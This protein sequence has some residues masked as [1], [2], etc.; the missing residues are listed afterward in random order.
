MKISQ[1]ACID[2]LVDHFDIISTSLV[3]A[4][5]S[6]GFRARQKGEEVCTKWYRGSL[7]SLLRLA[8]T[9]RPDISNLFQEIAR[10]AYDPSAK[11]WGAVTKIL[12]Y[13]KGTRELTL[14]YRKA[15]RCRSEAFA[16][17][18]NAEDH[19]NRRSIGGVVTVF[20][21]TALSWMSKT[22]TCVTLS[23]AEA[24]YLTLAD[25][26]KNVLYPRVHRRHLRLK[27]PNMR[28]EISADN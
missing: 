17:A 7:G 18:I 12:Q 23:S 25:C 1:I 9:T 21:G 16:D 19:E 22:Q 24:E 14:T 13:L 2:Q 11:H 20:G 4:C 6:V 15:G 5:S 8:N 27:L 10:R 3:F 26:A 28:V